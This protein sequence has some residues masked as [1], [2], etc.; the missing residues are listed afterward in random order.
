MFLLYLIC[1]CTVN[2][3]N[4]ENGPIIDQMREEILVEVKNELQMQN[5]VF[6]TRFE[7]RESEAKREKR[8]SERKRECERREAE[9][10]QMFQK[11]EGDMKQALVELE[12][13]F[14]LREQ[15]LKEQMRADSEVESLMPY[16]A[17]CGYRDSL[18]HDDSGKFITT[19]G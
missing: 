16:L 1:L 14:E 6:W 3:V 17:M 8:E 11:R 12:K 2:N 7:E 9:L 19:T 5:R 4:G 13:K 10:V 15:K 18:G